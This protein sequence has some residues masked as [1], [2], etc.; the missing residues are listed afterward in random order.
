MLS[1]LLS[2]WYSRQGDAAGVGTD[3][4]GLVA[5]HDLLRHDER[6]RDVEATEL[7]KVARSDLQQPIPVLLGRQVQGQRRCR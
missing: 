2:G 7:L 6:R 3:G 5:V 4:D 1:A